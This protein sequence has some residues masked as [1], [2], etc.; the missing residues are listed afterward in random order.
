VADHF[1]HGMIHR[2][3][4][5]DMTPLLDNLESIQNPSYRQIMAES[6]AR[7]LSKTDP[8]RATE[9]IASIGDEE[10]RVRAYQGAAM[11]YTQKDSRSAE[12]WLEML[13]TGKERRYAIF[14]FAMQNAE[15]SPE[16][17]AYWAL[18]IAEP[19]V[20]ERLLKSVLYSWSRSDQAQAQS[21]AASA[22][23]NNLLPTSR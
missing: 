1:I 2:L 7:D 6:T 5:A 11:G 23:Y 10:T 17:S 20:R 8:G 12:R 9:W 19:D 13:P 15:R 21:W 14:G 22:G 16:Q 3:N 18:R 4:R